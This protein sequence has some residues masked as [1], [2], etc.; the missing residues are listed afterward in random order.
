MTSWRATVKPPGARCTQVHAPPGVTS[1]TSQTSFGMRR[2]IDLEPLADREPGPVEGDE[3]GNRGGPF[4]PALDVAEYV[5]HDSDRCV[6][7]NAT[8]RNY[9]PDGA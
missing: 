8:I 3:P 6:D 5:L 4:G 7:L 2:L 9:V 1:V